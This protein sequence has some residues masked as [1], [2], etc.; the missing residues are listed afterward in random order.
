MSKGP[1]VYAG[2]LQGVS[3]R[4]NNKLP[5]ADLR[6]L[7][8]GFRFSNVQTFIQSGNVI[9]TS[10][11]APSALLLEAAIEERFAIKTNVIL[12]TASELERAVKRNPFAV[13][14][15]ARVQNVFGTPGTQR[16][17]PFVLR[18]CRE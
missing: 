14:E 11:N 16:K 10:K 9:F 5:M 18:R 12:L 17:D 15:D 1:S 4:G 8:E 13:T 2:F 7:C 6:W 3:V